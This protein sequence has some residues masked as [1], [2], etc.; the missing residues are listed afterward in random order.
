LS[1]CRWRGS[2]ST[3]T[4]A[5]NGLKQG[6]RAMI[7]YEAVGPLKIGTTK[8]QGGRGIEKRQVAKFFQEH[9]QICSKRGVYVFCI[10]AAKGI[11]PWYVGR[12]TKSFRQECLTPD[13]LNKYHSAL[14]NR[15]KGTPVLFLVCHPQQRGA[16]N[17][18]SMKAVEKYWIGLTSEINPR[19]INRHHN[20]PRAW[21]IK[22][23]IGA[24][25]GQPTKSSQALRKMLM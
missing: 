15:N 11:L 25:Q 2:D 1:C 9:E 8:Q 17:I 21:A 19:L 4:N 16:I 6:G 10:G 13:K 3:A 5:R 20:K 12:A 23:V 14:R 18:K 22:G 24:K 7:E